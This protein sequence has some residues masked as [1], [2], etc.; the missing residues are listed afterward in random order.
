MLNDQQNEV[1]N[2]TPTK[3]KKASSGRAKKAVAKKAKT[4]KPKVAKK[5]RSKAANPKPNARTAK[6]AKARKST[7]TKKTVTH[8]K[9]TKPV[10]SQEMALL[11]QE[12]QS[13]DDLT[14]CRDKIR[15]AAVL[16]YKIQQ[17][18]ALLNDMKKEHAK[19]VNE[20]LPDLCESLH[21]ES[22]TTDDGVQIQIKD[23]IRG[24]IPTNEKLRQESLGYLR[25]IKGGPLIKNTV[26]ARFERGENPK[27]I[28]V[29]KVL[30]KLDIEFEKKQDVHHL[31]LAKFARELLEDGQEV[32][33]EK[34]G[35]Y[36]GK[37]AKIT[38]PVEV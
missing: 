28:E 25:K 26:V 22:Q 19:L 21:I 6:P 7:K 9:K 12:T 34:L 2:A 29:T 4:A 32:D 13:Q 8:K 1:E 11:G 14:L 37:I 10:T 35:L 27:A 24:K 15:Q 36:H 5:P 16:Q 20:E 17:G 38:L 18:E 23:F 30:K 3:K 31:S 33:L